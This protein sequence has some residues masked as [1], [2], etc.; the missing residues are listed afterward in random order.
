MY[1]PFDQ[2]MQAYPALSLGLK[3]EAG[4]CRHPFMVVAEIELL[5]Y[6]MGVNLAAL[7]RVASR[8]R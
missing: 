5:A 1:T 3:K 7:R 8:M 6:S 4:A 2:K